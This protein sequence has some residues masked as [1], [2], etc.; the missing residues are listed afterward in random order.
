MDEGVRFG[1]WGWMAIAA[2]IGAAAAFLTQKPWEAA[3]PAHMSLIVLVVAAGVAGGEADTL[4]GFV[5]LLT[6]PIGAY[7]V[8]RVVTDPIAARIMPGGAP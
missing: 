4:R 5:L 7:K 1:L 6:A 3:R 2:I 8:A